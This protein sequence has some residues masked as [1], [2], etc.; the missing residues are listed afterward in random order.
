MNP[1]YGLPDG[2]HRLPNGKVIRG[3]RFAR[4]IRAAMIHIKWAVIGEVIP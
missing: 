4:A 3:S 1:L 2:F